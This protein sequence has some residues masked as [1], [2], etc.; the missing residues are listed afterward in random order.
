M[1]GNSLS[2]LQAT[3]TYTQTQEANLKGQQ[4]TLVSADAA[5]VATQLKTS[6]TQHT[7]LLGVIGLLGKGSLFDYIK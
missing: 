4:S 3:S 2:R 5:V 1:L 7:A 6:E